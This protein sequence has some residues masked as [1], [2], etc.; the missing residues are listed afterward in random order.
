LHPQHN[1]IERVAIA[2]ISYSD[3]DDLSTY[4]DFVTIRKNS[5]FLFLLN[6]RD[7]KNDHLVWNDGILILLDSNHSTIAIDRVHH[8]KPHRSSV[9][10]DGNN[11]GCL[12]FNRSTQNMFDDDT[13]VLRWYDF[14]TGQVTQEIP[15]LA[16]NRSLSP[17]S[18][19]FIG[20]GELICGL[21]SSIDI[22]LL[23]LQYGPRLAPVI[24][25]DVWIQEHGVTP[26]AQ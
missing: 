12:L 11:F 16:T 13:I 19:F 5:S 26:P 3:T 17:E 24:D 6:Q 10:G 20:P 22:Q 21:A 1:A 7:V 9:I 18:V 4:G 15:L 23:R 25:P 8:F 2:D 14:N